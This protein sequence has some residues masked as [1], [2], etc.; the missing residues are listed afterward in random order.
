MSHSR[1][2]TANVIRY[3]AGT[4]CMRAANIVLLPLY[5]YVLVPREFGIYALAAAMFALITV[6]SQCGMQQALTQKILVQQDGCTIRDLFSTAVNMILLVSVG[7]AVLC[8]VASRPIA[9]LV[10]SDSARYPLVIIGAL[11]VVAENWCMLGIRMLKIEEQATAVL[12]A[13]IGIALL[14]TGLTLWL[15]LG[16]GMGITGI[17]LADAVSFAIVGAGLF[18]M[19][20]RYYKPLLHAAVARAALRFGVPILLGG[21][22]TMGVQVADRFFIKAFIDTDAVGIYSMS[23]RIAL[24]MNVFVMGFRSAWMPRILKSYGYYRY[25]RFAGRIFTRL[26]GATGIIGIAVSL[27]IKDLLQSPLFDDA[28]LHGMHIAPFVL[29]GYGF[30]A[31]ASFYSVAGFV[32]G[33]G[34]VFL[35]ADALAF[36]VNVAANLMLIPRFGI[37]GAACA[38]ALAFAATAGYLWLVSREKIRIV[39]EPRRIGMV[40]G[41][42]TVGA[43]IG[44]VLDMVVVD[45]AVVVGMGVTL[46]PLWKNNSYPKESNAGSTRG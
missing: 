27:G 8:S 23:Y 43:V 22:F 26:V 24:I 46:L 40:L 34:V 45:I 37:T 2:F 39:Y 21:F 3:G 5:T 42:L 25:H 31:L 35:K 12:F 1:S 16:A 6:V 41:I 29:A 19:L 36:V 33:N 7:V 38:T 10:F 17:L 9:R 15:L 13:S 28:Y 20:R 32:Q 44:A 30:T 18:F 11:G 4:F 14:K